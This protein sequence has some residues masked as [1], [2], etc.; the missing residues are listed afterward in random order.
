MYSFYVPN[1]IEKNKK[2]IP[3]ST[4]KSW[5]KNEKKLHKDFFLLFFW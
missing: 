3:F 4:E 5:K 1:R 2:N